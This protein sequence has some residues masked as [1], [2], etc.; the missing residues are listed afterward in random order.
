MNPL[1]LRFDAVAILLPALAVITGVLSSC[2]GSGARPAE[3]RFDVSQSTDAASLGSVQF[4][5][6]DVELLDEGGRPHRFALV[7]TPPWQTEQVALI[8]LAGNPERRHVALTGRLERGSPDSFRGVRF[9]VGVPFELNHVD[10]LTA[11]APLDR[12]DLFWA[13][14]SGHKFLRADVIVDG[15]EW[16]FHLGSTGCSS[17]SA[18]RPPAAPCAQ[19]NQ[20]RVELRGDPLRQLIRFRLAPI[21]AAAKAANHVACTGAYAHEPACAAAYASTGLNVES[22]TCPEG[23]CAR[24]TLWG[25]E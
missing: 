5:V 12:G 1:S 8:D 17:A 19:P 21:V 25:L 22:G 20:V 9:T 6:H 23:S 16:S 2:S 18:L 7:A 15:R 24:Q 14:Q 4:Y 10:P 3:I 13:W 11:P